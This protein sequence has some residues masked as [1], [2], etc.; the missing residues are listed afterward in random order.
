[1]LVSI[2]FGLLSKQHH[3]VHKNNNIFHYHFQL[4][5]RCRLNATKYIISMLPI[6]IDNVG[7]TYDVLV[8]LKFIVIFI[9]IKRFSKKCAKPQKIT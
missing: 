6:Y 1:M 8:K 5:M 3:H 7:K 4:G 2:P 9:E